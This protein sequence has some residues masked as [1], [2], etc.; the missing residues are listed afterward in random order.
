MWRQ[1]FAPIVIISEEKL[2]QNTGNWMGAAST[3]NWRFGNWQI[4]LG[5]VLLVPLRLV[6]NDKDEDGQIQDDIFFPTHLLKYMGFTDDESVQQSININ[7]N[8]P[9]PSFLHVITRVIKGILVWAVLAAS[10][11]GPGTCQKLSTRGRSLWA[12]ICCL[13]FLLFC[14]EDNKTNKRSFDFLAGS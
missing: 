14:V 13:V 9:P 3:K 10:I 8:S 7:I 4:V 11:V 6:N 1:N 5:C 12:A 2:L